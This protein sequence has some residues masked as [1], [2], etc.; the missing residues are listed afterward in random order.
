MDDDGDFTARLVSAADDD[1]FDELTSDRDGELVVD[2]DGEGETIVSD[3]DYDGGGVGGDG[4]DVV[5]GGGGSSIASTSDAVLGAHEDVEIGDECE[6]GELKFEEGGDDD[7]DDGNGGGAITT[8]TAGMAAPAEVVRQVVTHNFIRYK[9]CVCKGNCVDGMLFTSFR[10]HLFVCASHAKTRQFRVTKRK[11]LG[12]S[13]R[14][15][16]HPLPYCGGGNKVVGRVCGDCRMFFRDDVDVHEM[17]ECNGSRTPCT[18]C[19]SDIP[20]YLNC[21]HAALCSSAVTNVVI[22]N[23][24]LGYEIPKGLM[25]HVI[26]ANTGSDNTALDS[27]CCMEEVFMSGVMTTYSRKLFGCFFLHANEIHPFFSSPSDACTFS[28]D[29]VVSNG[30]VAYVIKANRWLRFRFERS[31]SDTLVRCTFQQAKVSK[32]E[33]DLTA[34]CLQS[35]NPVRVITESR[36]ALGVKGEKTIILPASFDTFQMATYYFPQ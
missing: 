29:R 27:V 30:E 2:D 33:F 22:R 34:T 13:K 24:C 16:S 31:G 7:N 10:E 20:R 21:V 36:C 26:G 32:F 6:E 23:D 17:Y 3:D 12:S 5:G 14:V 28:F 19:K 11:R 18:N 25:T 9:C 1:D 15:F 8:T 35:C 4:D